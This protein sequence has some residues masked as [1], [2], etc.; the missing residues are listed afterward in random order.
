MGLSNSKY[1]EV[2]NISLQ[3]IIGDKLFMQTLTSRYVVYQC[4]HDPQKFGIKCVTRDYDIITKDKLLI[5]GL[6]PFELQQ[7]L[8]VLTNE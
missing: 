3:Y 8:E 7:Y 4:L 2:P 1:R 6:S 5:D